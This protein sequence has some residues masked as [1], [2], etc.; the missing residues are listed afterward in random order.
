[1]ATQRADDEHDG[2]RP[3]RRRG[4]W[5]RAHGG[6]DVGSPDGSPGGS[7]GGSPG[8]GHAVGHANSPGAGH[9]N[10]PDGS[11]GNSSGAS[12]AASHVDAPWR[13]GDN[14]IHPDVDGSPEPSA[15]VYARAFMPF[16]KSTRRC[17]SCSAAGSARGRCG[18]NTTRPF[19][20]PLERR[21]ALENHRR[22]AWQGHREARAAD[23][24][25]PPRQAPTLH[26]GRVADPSARTDLGRV[27][28][29]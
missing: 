3:R 23:D 6:S 15:E 16:C 2:R 28:K 8:V 25:D 4:W 11:P 20:L 19:S 9:E 26:R 17:R 13:I 5:G 18:A 24:A 14:I 10:S 1:M 12:H 21:S 29:Y 7:R 22:R 27:L